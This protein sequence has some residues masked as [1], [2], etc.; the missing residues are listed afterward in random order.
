MEGINSEMAYIG[1]RVLREMDQ[2]EMT[3]IACLCINAPYLD[4]DQE[5]RLVISH[6]LPEEL[7]FEM[8]GLVFGIALQ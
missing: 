4:H 8:S 2:D 5:V 7:P 1:T 6:R 3:R